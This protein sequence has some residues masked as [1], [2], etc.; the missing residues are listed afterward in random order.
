MLNPKAG[1]FIVPL[2]VGKRIENWG[3]PR[4]KIVE[5][6]WWKEYRVDDRLLIAATP[7]QHFSGRGLAS[8]NKTLWTSWV[9]AGPHHKIFFSGDSGYFDGFKRIGGKYGPF[10]MT[11]IECGAYNEKWHFV[12][13]FPEEVVRAHLDLKGKILHPVHWGTFKLALHSWYEPMSRLSKAADSEKVTIATPIIGET[14][15]YGYPITSK[16]W[17]KIRIGL[18]EDN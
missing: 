6:D 11:F 3:I 12:H 14:T 13:M 4:K 15:V 7:A 9:I 10:D 18:M 2:L 16:P 5:V 17:W 1:L 8:R